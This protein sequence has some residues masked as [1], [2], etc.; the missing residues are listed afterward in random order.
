MART[1]G[2]NG[3]KTVESL[4]KEATRLIYEHG[5]EGMNLRMLAEAVG[6][7]PGSLYNHI[8]NKQELLYILLND[9]MD[10]LLEGI[11]AALAGSATPREALMRFIAFHIQ[12]H[13]ERKEDVFIGNA[14]LRSLEPANFKAITARRQKYESYLKDIL[15]AGAGQDQFHVTDTKVA[16]YATIAMLTGVCTWYRPGGRYSIESLV[17]IYT[18]MVM[19]GVNDPCPAQKPAKSAVRRRSA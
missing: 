10:E 9:V 6:I 5:F 3:A 13:A 8:A 12:F 2:S 7:Q 15:D 4:K 16:T 17:E 18:S 19:S 11:E 1:F 14:E